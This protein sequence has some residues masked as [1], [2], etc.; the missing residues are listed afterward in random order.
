MREAMP[1]AR[2]D[3]G[4]A[5]Q[6]FLAEISLVLGLACGEAGDY[7]VGGQVCDRLDTMPFVVMWFFVVCVSRD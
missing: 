2:P 6:A 4:P 5:C 3:E 1:H 7:A